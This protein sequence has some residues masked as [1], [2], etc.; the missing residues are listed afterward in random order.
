MPYKS[1]SDFIEVLKKNKEIISIDYP[2]S[3]EYEITEIIDRVVKSGGPALLF[4]NN[5][6]EFPVLINA[7]GSER[8]MCIALGVE[9]LD[10]IAESIQKVFGDFLSPKKSIIDKIKFL[11]AL[12]KL[13]NILPKSQKSR[14]QCQQVIINEPDLYKLPILKCWPH[15]G[16]SFITL[17]VVHTIDYNTGMRNVGMYRMQV[18]SNNTTGMHWHLHKGSAK[19]YD[20]YKLHKA[21]MPVV[22]TLGGDPVYTYVATAPLPENIDEYILAGFIRNKAVKLVKCISCNIEVPADVDFV[23][24]G[25]IDT[26][27]DLVSEGPFG[28]H[29]GY[30]SLQDKYPLFHVTCITHRRNAVYPATIVGIP[31]QEDEWLAKATERIFLAPLRTALLPEIIDMKLP[32]EGVFHNLCIVKINKTYQG[33]AFKVMNAL[34]GAGQMMFNKYLIVVD[35]DVDI[36]NNFEVLKAVCTNSFIPDSFNIMSGPLD[37]LDHSGPSLGMGSK[38]GID[39]TVKT[40]VEKYVVT[41]Y[42]S[43]FKDI[44]YNNILRM[45]KDIVKVNHLYD[46]TDI[47]ILVLNII[48]SEKHFVKKLHQNLIN[49]GLIN[50]VKILFYFDENVD[51]KDYSMIT[52]LALGNTDP[53]RDIYFIN[54]NVNK[55]I[56]GIDATRK[57]QDFDNFDRV[58]PNI[59]VTD[60]KTIAKIDSI[61]DILG[62]GNFIK[63]PSEKYKSLVLPGNAEVDCQ[64]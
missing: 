63:S 36:N 21:R 31:P 3:C 14:G 23:I 9:K 11:P 15:D 10:D 58:W 1:L 39:A 13:S 29:T 24:E 19:H 49:S 45:F 46:T 27:E 64:S 32:T 22:V 60:D 48:K 35:K 20:V 25:Y 56:I 7:F 18:M 16:G 33:Q 17:P 34:W 6:T 4:T 12:S 53:A 62:L 38:M 5:G 50:G 57:L 2:I 40:C 59:I 61:W 26:T 41:D 43:N 47:P 28:D 42:N 37:I 54:N 52:W 8:R 55:V 51:T 44:D 30:Y